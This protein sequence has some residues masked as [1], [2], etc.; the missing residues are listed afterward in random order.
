MSSYSNHPRYSKIFHKLAMD[1]SPEGFRAQS[2]AKDARFLIKIVAWDFQ[3]NLVPDP[4]DALR[5]TGITRSR[6]DD[7]CF[8]L[9]LD[10]I[11]TNIHT[12]GVWC[13]LTDLKSRRVIPVNIKNIELSSWN[14]DY[15]RFYSSDYGRNLKGS[16]IRIHGGRIIGKNDEEARIGAGSPG[17]ILTLG[18]TARN[19]LPR[20]IREA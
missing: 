8:C 17:D 7:I 2:R 11:P 13:S 20:T 6:N 14:E 10:A 19:E 9:D 4:M 18:F 12:F 16:F 15:T 3:G 5:S 1:Y